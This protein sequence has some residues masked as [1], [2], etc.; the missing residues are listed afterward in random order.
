[1]GLLAYLKNHMQARRGANAA[2]QKVSTR[3]HSVDHSPFVALKRSRSF[4]TELVQ[5]PQAGGRQDPVGKD[6]DDPDV[7]TESEEGEVDN[8]TQTL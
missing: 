8:V 3:E 1:M 4:V 2:E 5:I 7:F 6:Y